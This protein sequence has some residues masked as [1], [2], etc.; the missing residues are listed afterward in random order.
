M[1]HPDGHSQTTRL[2]LCAVLRPQDVLRSPAPGRTF[3]CGLATARR[4]SISKP[5]LPWASYLPSGGISTY[6]EEL[7][8]YNK[9]SQRDGARRRPF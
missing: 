7:P 8:T 2:T 5:R 9:D 1:S 4:P 6:D 3:A